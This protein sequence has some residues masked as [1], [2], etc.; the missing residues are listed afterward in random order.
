MPTEFKKQLNVKTLLS[1]LAIAGILFVSGVYTGYSIN[2][3]R[4]SAIEVDMRDVVK[5]IEDFQLQFLFF[6][7]LGGDAACPLLAD[8]LKNI[9]KRSYEIGRKL[10]ENNPD[11]GEI[12]DY[13]YYEDLRERYGR[14]LTSY[15]LLSTKMKGVCKSQ[16][17]TVIFFIEKE[18]CRK[19]NPNLCEAQG[20]V[21]DNL[22][23]IFEEKLL[24]FTLHADLKEPS[25]KALKNYYN[26]TG[27]P[28]LVIDGKNYENFQDKDTLLKT[29]CDIGLCQ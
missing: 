4:L 2:K 6:D 1:A 23:R 28:S 5:N 15:W 10:T 18:A 16:D 17:K 12:T 19:Q 21:L 29:L 24:V 8:S 20:F 27:Y 13:N 25:V 26:I 11:S 14:V 7:T 3:E 22:K 9:N